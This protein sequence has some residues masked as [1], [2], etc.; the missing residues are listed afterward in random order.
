M[1]EKIVDLS[2]M[3]NNGGGLLLSVVNFTSY[4]IFNQ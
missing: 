4:I 1:A 3:I 2:Y